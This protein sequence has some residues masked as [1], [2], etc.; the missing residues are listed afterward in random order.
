MKKSIIL[1]FILTFSVVCHGKTLWQ[2]TQTG[3]TLSQVESLFPEAKR[4]KP[5]SET[6]LGDGAQELLKIEDYKINIYYYDA[7]FYFLNGKLKQVTLVLKDGQSVGGAT[8]SLVESLRIKYGKEVIS[9]NDR[10]VFKKKWI[11]KEKTNINVSLYGGKYLT[12]I[13]SDRDD[14]DLNKL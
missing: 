9:Q 3:M 10:F 13:Y 14:L 5:S 6:M 1:L 12:V 2:K 8:E 11:T 4:Q 7:S